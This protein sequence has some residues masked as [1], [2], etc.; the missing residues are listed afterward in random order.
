M[1]GNTETQTDRTA[2]PVVHLH[3]VPTGLDPAGV[4]TADIRLSIGGQPLHLDIAVPA[5]PAPLGDLLPVFHGLAN[6]EVDVA[7]AAVERQGQTIS[8]CKGCGACCRQP[9]PIT[10]TEARAL[11]RLVDGM[12]EPRRS[13]V[14]A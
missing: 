9:V 2:L 6:V 14:R 1:S 13:Q 10:E 5:G 11:V 7:V 4:A 8:C 3:A 12:P